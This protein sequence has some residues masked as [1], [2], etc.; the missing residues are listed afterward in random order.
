MEVVTKQ[1]NLSQQAQDDYN[2]ICRAVS[3][4]QQAYAVL[5]DRYRGAI[6]QLVLKMVSNR[7]DAEDLTLEAFGKAFNNLRAYSPK[8]AFSTWLFRIA[9][10]NCIDHI[11][12]KRIN[13]FSI[14]DPG[15]GE[16]PG[17]PFSDCLISGTRTP[18]E[19][20]IHLQK[21][22]FMRHVIA[23]LNEKYRLMI[24]LRYF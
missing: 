18:E 11:R 22:Q 8:Y 9:V 15:E 17:T 23:Q 12:K 20:F 13:P 10:N 2:W 7:E 1:P 21:L 19:H 16:G 5:M 4:D 6:H 14:D 24:E 3:G